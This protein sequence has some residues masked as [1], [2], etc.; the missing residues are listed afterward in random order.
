MLSVAVPDSRQSYLTKLLVSGRTTK[1]KS[2][3]SGPGYFSAMKKLFQSISGIK[4]IKGVSLPVT[5]LIQCLPQGCF[6]LF[7][8][9]GLFL[10]SKL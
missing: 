2:I 5:L 9:D 4:E 8:T 6:I 3:N 7:F 1:A 10:E